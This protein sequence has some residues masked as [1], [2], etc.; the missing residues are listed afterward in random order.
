MNKELLLLVISTI[1]LIGLGLG[2]VIVITVIRP[3]ENNTQIVTATLSF[4]GPTIMAFIAVFKGIQNSNDLKDIKITTN[5]QTEH[6]IDQAAKLATLTEQV[7]STKVA[8]EVAAVTAANTATAL[9]VKQN[10]IDKSS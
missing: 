6:A 3:S 1:A 8:A 2:T 4:L 5:G 9:A 7:T 10:I